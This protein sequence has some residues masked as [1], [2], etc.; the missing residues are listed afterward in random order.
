MKQE[1]EIPTDNEAQKRLRYTLGLLQSF[2][3]ETIEQVDRSYALHKIGEQTELTRL[4]EAKLN[5]P[6]GSMME[7]SER[8]DSQLRTVIDSIV[9]AFLRQKRELLASAFVDPVTSSNALHY[10][11]ALDDDS[12]E[13]RNQIF[14]FFERY[15]EVP[16]AEKFPVLFQFIPKD[17]IAEMSSAQR[18]DVGE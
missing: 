15:D 3:E 18:V 12:D 5:D 6:L 9:R 14:D 13:N 16:F 10:I 11:I 17:L 1:V 8:V 2:L 7:M 4:I